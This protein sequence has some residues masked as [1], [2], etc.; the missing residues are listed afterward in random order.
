VAG[1]VRLA[2]LLPRQVWRGQKCTMARFYFIDI[3]EIVESST[4]MF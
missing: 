4:E 3:K 2:T 1:R